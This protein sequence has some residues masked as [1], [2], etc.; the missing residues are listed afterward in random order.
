M[1][2]TTIVFGADISNKQLERFS[3]SL[4]DAQRKGKK[5]HI[6]TTKKPTKWYWELLGNTL[7]VL[8]MMALASGL[9]WLIIFFVKKIVGL[10]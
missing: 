2:D 5:T 6:P 9:I 3:E 7:G 1:D 4:A 8:F 10:F